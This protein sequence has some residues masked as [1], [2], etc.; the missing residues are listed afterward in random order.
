MKSDVERV[1]TEGPHGS[2]YDVYSPLRRQMVIFTAAIGHLLGYCAII[3]L[4]ALK[5]LLH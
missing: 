2:L 1:D 3:Y 4:P 5:V